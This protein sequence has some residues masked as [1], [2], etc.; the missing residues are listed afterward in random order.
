MK[1]VV[2]DPQRGCDY[3]KKEKKRE[4]E[5]EK[6][7]EEMGKQTNKQTGQFFKIV[8]MKRRNSSMLPAG[9]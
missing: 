3:R 5:E 1:G 7:K 2:V 6:K 4:E 9:I 8:A